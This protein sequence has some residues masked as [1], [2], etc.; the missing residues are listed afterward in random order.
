MRAPTH[1]NT[2][3]WVDDL[4]GFR[5]YSPEV[6]LDIVPPSYA[7]Y[8]IHI[9]ATACTAGIIVLH[10]MSGG[11]DGARGQRW[12][13]GAR[14]EPGGIAPHNRGEGRGEEKGGARRP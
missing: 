8:S 3:T 4:V 11:K 13:P 2:Q 7:C 5:V 6:Y 14:M 10:V 9:D 12:S 1:F